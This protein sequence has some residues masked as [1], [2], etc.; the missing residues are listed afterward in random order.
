MLLFITYLFTNFWPCTVTAPYWVL[1]SIL[2]FLQFYPSHDFIQMA[3]NRLIHLVVNQP[4]LFLTA[5][6]DYNTLCFS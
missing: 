2:L 6:I 1:F 5:G 4:T 3:L